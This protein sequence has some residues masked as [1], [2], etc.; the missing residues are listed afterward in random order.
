L[1]V[2]FAIKNKKTLYSLSLILMLAMS[3]IIA[4]AQPSSAQIGIPQPEK[5]AGYIT[6]A[7]TLVGVGQTLTC[8]AWVFPLP[9]TYAY[10][11]YFRGFYNVEVT[12]VRPDGTKDTFMP[13]DGTGGYIA[14]QMTS[15]GSM[16]FYYK[17]QMAGN[18]SVS[19]TMP[20]QNITDN[21]YT[22]AGT[23]QY[24]GCTS[25]TFYFT[26]QTDPVLAGLLNGYP[27]SPLPNA[28]VYW[29]Y[30]INDNNREW[31]QIS[32][33]WTGVS[34]TMATVNSPTALRWQPYGSGPNTGHI[35]WKDQVKTGGIVGGAYGSVS[36]VGSTTV[37]A[38]P[39]SMYVIMDGMVFCNILN[40]QPVGQS[41][42]Q[43]RCWDLATGKVLYTANGSI[44]SGIHLP[45][46][47][48]Q[49][50]TTAQ[51]DAPVLLE[52]SFGSYVQPYLFG[53]AT[54]AGITYW[55]Y[56]DALTGVLVRQIANASSARLIDGTPLAFGA[57]NSPTVLGGAYLY[58]WNMT[59]VSTT[60]ASA[61]NWSTGITWKVPLPKAL[62]NPRGQYQ[63]IFAVSSDLSTVIINN[64]FQYWGYDAN[65]G[66]LLWNRTLDYQPNTNQELPLIN[67]DDFILIDPTAATFKCYSIKTGALLWETP[68]FA[69]SPWATT[70]TIYYTETN[71]L[72]NMYF[73]FPDGSMRAYSLTDGHLLWTSKPFASTEYVNNAVP[74]V[75][76]GTVLVDGKLYEYGGYSIGYE[77]DPVPRFAMLVCINAT[78]GDIIFTLNGG[79]LPNAA[80][81]G[82]VIGSGIFD[83]NL[84]CLGKGT[85]STTVSAPQ[86][87]IAA[88]TSAIISG[89]VLDKSPASSGA[90]LMAKYPNGV[91]A[92]SDADMSVWMD[93]LHM[94]NATLLNNPPNCNG[95]PVSLTAVDSNGNAINI[96]TTTSNNKGT[97]GF[98]WTPTTPGLYTIYANFAGSDSYYTSSAATYATVASVASPTPAPTSGTQSAVSNSDMIMYFAATGIAIIVAIAVATV[99]IIRKK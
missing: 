10:Y 39:T 8:N 40:T 52:S 26:V 11:P 57:A 14:G 55:N 81:N 61:Q 56:Y 12:F 29:D 87:T 65:T 95:V 51:G 60:G 79:V 72:N 13:V 35:V 66:A 67:V 69:D 33:D 9:T 99:L 86:T 94:Q 23:V 18:W 74:F 19:F 58:R 32:G 37:Y 30:P 92:I 75:H 34:A 41:Y 4:F 46:T 85:T 16:Y 44:S 25:N 15:L 98:E 93:Y 50:T 78:T 68:S 42:G 71:D 84:Y 49:Q 62:A 73:G 45:G 76:G 88:G 53:T 5:T 7:P 2:N 83:G 36:Y 1:D 24:S 54:V 63:S 43:F 27:W 38:A 47:T 89:T 77:I 6:V 20:A 91:P 70:W 3:V 22:P 82:Y 48:F 80:A 28:N 97:Y 21:T 90:D 17:P 64:Y 96:G 31:S 59:S